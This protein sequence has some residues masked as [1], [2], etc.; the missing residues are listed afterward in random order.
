MTTIL[1]TRAIA[2]LALL[3]LVY[4]PASSQETKAV[5][6]A[7]FATARSAQTLGLLTTVIPVALGGGLIVAGRDEGTALY[8][9]YLLASSG[10]IFGPSIADWRGGLHG[11][12]VGGMFLRMGLAWGGLITATI[13]CLPDC[14]NQTATEVIFL[15]S[16]AAA[17]GLAVWEL[18]TVKNR[19]IKASEGRIGL[20]PTFSPQ[21]G[22]IGFAARV[23]F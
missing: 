7:A 8:V 19:V 5:D 16:Q 14:E 18:A 11:R 1:R 10:V 4:R 23:R 3:A 15:G 13:V 20:T 22:A 17:L 2:L 9:G 21:T 6:S 12:G